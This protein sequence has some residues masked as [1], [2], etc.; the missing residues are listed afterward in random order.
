MKTRYIFT[1][2]SLETIYNSFVIENETIL[3]TNISELDEINDDKSIGKNII[4]FNAEALNS[5][6]LDEY[7]KSDKAELLKAKF[8]SS[9]DDQLL[10]NPSDL[11]FF[12]SFEDNIGIW[13]DS[14]YFN[15]LK[16]KT[17][18]L[19]KSVFLPDYLLFFERKNIV[20]NLGSHYC[21]RLKDGRGYSGHYQKINAL[22]KSNTKILD[23]L[24]TRDVVTEE[25]VFLQNLNHTSDELDLISLVKKYHLHHL[26]SLNL[27]KSPFNIGRLLSLDLISFPDFKKFASLI[28]ATFLVSLL[29]NATLKSQYE[30]VT[31][32]TKQLFLNL[33][34][35]SSRLVNPKAQIDQLVKGLKISD[36]QNYLDSRILNFLDNYQISELKGIEINTD[37][38]FSVIYLERLSRQKL[39]IIMSFLS[40]SDLIVEENF[41]EVNNQFNGSIKVL[42]NE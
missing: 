33:G 7:D 11:T 15:N 16:Q 29:I 41:T 40:S 28:F 1:D 14:N 21:F 19:R 31:K 34:N 4:F 25:L 32:E 3:K 10:L 17:L 37:D 42:F 35:N 30:S 9:H 22:L 8:F 38:K 36:N 13:G 24:E 6:S 18:D 20:V 26:S 27:L 23:G 5:C 2:S 39:N 12:S